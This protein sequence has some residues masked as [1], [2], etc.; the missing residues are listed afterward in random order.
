M[1]SESEKEY[2]EENRKDLKFKCHTCG[3]ISQD[4]VV[5][6]CNN[7]DSK[8]M[9]EKEGN[10][11]CPDCFSKTTDKYMCRICESTDVKLITKV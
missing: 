10:F 9:V 5:F 7:C 4:D 1:S 3:S 8:E 2:I 6:L 11:F